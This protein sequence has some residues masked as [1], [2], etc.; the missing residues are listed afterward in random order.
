MIPES[1]NWLELAPLVQATDMICTTII[2]CAALGTF[3]YIISSSL[4]DN[5]DRT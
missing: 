2:I 3:L 5:H 4:K 1:A